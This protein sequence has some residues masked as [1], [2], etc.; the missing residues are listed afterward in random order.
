LPMN[1]KR[2]PERTARLHTVRETHIYIVGRVKEEVSKMV[3][4]N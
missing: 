1:L 4:P 2:A 3:R